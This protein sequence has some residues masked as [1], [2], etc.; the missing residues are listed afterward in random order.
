MVQ[1]KLRNSVLFLSE[2]P[3]SGALRKV[4]GV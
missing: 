1:R 2:S 4:S 3:A